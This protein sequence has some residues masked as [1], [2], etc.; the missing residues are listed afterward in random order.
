[1]DIEPFIERC[2][3]MK[4]LIVLINTLFFLNMS[5]Y[6]A[7]V[8][9]SKQQESFLR[10]MSCQL[11]GIKNFKVEFEQQR[12]LSIMFE[13][14]ISKGVCYFEKP[15]KM[16]WEIS[17]PYSSI[18]IYNSDQVAKYEIEN[19]KI[20][21]LNF[22]AADI[23]R[24]VLQQ[25]ISWMQGDFNEADGLY[26]LEV[27]KGSVY[28]V[29]LIPISEAMRTNLQK[30]ELHI[31][32]QDFQMNEVVIRESE[33]DFIQIKFMNKQDNIALPEKVFDPAMPVNLQ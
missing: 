2:F 23:M 20:N 16:R 28:K 7:D 13:P 6:S 18:L 25:I 21:K 33:T 4:I 8:L 1:M 22:G 15:D 26:A 27:Y 11:K 31:T 17:S 30:I 12:H 19:G 24:K 14:L 10:D 29:V 3:M 5:S 32:V 9:N